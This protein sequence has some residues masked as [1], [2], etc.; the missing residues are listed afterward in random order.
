M[1]IEKL[2]KFLV[3]MHKFDKKKELSEIADEI[4]DKSAKVCDFLLKGDK[5]QLDIA[6][7]D[8]IVNL[9]RLA[10]ENNFNIPVT[11]REKLNIK[12]L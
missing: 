6:I 3:N 5:Q 2:Q 11:I 9:I 1:E 4:K 8:L 7:A 12:I 10:G